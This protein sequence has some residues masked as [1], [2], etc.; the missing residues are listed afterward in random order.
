[1]IRDSAHHV[2]DRI[3]GLDRNNKRLKL[4]PFDNGFI[5]GSGTALAINNLSGTKY[6]TVMNDGHYGEID[7]TIETLLII[8][9]IVQETLDAFEWI[10]D[11]VHQPS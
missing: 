4:K 7:V 6:G 8:Q 3:R 1:M 10:G 11:K 9:S 2:E 5:K